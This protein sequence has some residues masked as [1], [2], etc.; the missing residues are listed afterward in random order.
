MAQAVGIDLGTTFSVI[1]HVDDDGWPRVIRNLE[2]RKSTPSVVLIRDGQIEVGEVALNQ[3]LIDSDH[4]VRWIKRA[5]GDRSYRFEGLSAA[6]ISAEILKKLKR[7]AEAGL[8]E[9]L[10]EAFVTCPAYF[11]GI[12]VEE[13]FRAGELAG[14]DVK[15]VVRE[16]VAAA[17]YWGAENLRP[18]ER[19]LVCDLGGGTFDATILELRDTRF[20][21]LATAGDRMLGGH[22]WTEVL[23]DEVRLRFTDIF[24]R[25]PTD[26][27]PTY[28]RLYEACE[29]G[30][31]DLS[32]GRQTTIACNYNGRAEQVTVTREE[33]EDLT[34]YKLDSVI[35]GAEQALGKAGLAWAELDHILMVGGATRM[36]QVPRALREASGKEP[37]ETGEADTMVAL[38][39]AVMVSG[40]LRTRSGLMMTDF[41]RTAARN[42]GTRV[43]V[44]HDGSPAI[45]N[46]RIIAAG[47]TLPAEE[48]RGDYEISVPDQEHFDV[49]VVEFDD[50]GQD[51]IIDTWRFTCPPN[52][53]KGAPV[54]VT[55]KYID[56]SGRPDVDAVY[57]NTGQTL[58][59]ERIEYRE[60]DLSELA[61]SARPR[62][63]VF[64]LDVSG[65]MSGAK[66]EAAKSA[67]ITH[68][69]EFLN[70][71]GGH[72]RV[73]VV[74]FSDDAEPVCELT[75]DPEAIGAAVGKITTGGGTAM[76][77][78]INEAA[79]LLQGTA[80]GVDAEIA[81]VT[82]GKPNN[83]DA[84]LKAAEDA[85]SQNISLS[86]LGIGETGVDMDFLRKLTPNIFSIEGA[87][88]LDEWISGFL[89]AA[90]GGERDTSGITWG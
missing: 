61:V 46:S 56:R 17:V 43:I 40:R 2:G 28:Q 63:V 24:G 12:E 58:A 3:F 83:A 65:S 42:L 41:D 21:P 50:V 45:E 9:E 68:A 80:E 72:C 86:V 4:V 64:A 39:A 34:A 90:G 8:G 79:G 85:R 47:A 23:L 22:D 77:A 52:A 29:Q 88:G 78:G 71:T 18:G 73:G 15:E 14:L 82:D 38:G 44:W 26:D 75:T 53:E 51:V 13:T 67:L 11:G 7:D 60:P 1:A 6:E 20:H 87:E 89:T 49:P 31:R 5:M 27:L 16:P 55:F 25:D 10:G 54:E 57:A 69:R 32:R 36:P 33:F 30:K 81:L 48:S 84:A 37:I 74:T 70:A 62:D 76:D 19:V 59:K 35:T 66:I